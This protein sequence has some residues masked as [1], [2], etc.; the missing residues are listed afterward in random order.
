MYYITSKNEIFARYLRFTMQYW[1][2]I[3]DFAYKK[4]THGHSLGIDHSL[5]SSNLFN[6]QWYDV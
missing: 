1:S 4:L 3:F 6:F 2:K 5:Q